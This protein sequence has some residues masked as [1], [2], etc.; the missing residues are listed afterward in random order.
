MAQGLR[1]WVQEPAP[2]KKKKKELK[3]TDNIYKL[4]KP[5]KYA[6]WKKA[7]HKSHVLFDYLYE[8][9]TICNSIE[10]KRM[11]ANGHGVFLW[12]GENILEIDN[13]GSLQFCEYIKII[14][15]IQ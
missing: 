3:S 4:H 8:M 14:N 13:E 1:P 11:T 6:K 7:S 2:Q 12:E 15:C 5:W 10:T 9:F